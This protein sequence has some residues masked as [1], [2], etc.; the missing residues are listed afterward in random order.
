MNYLKK[1]ASIPGWAFAAA[2]VVYN[3]L[4]LHFWIMDQLHWG[5]LLAIA[6]FALGFGGILAL[7]TSLFDR[8][9]SKRAAVVLGV[10]VTVISL[11]EYFISDAYQVFMTPVTVISGAGGVATDYTELV[12]SLIA[13]NLWRIGLMLLPVVLYGIFGTSSGRN[14]KHSAAIALAAVLCFAAGVGAVRNMTND[15]AKLDSAYEFDS[16]V[17]SFGL[18][19]ALTLDVINGSSEDEALDFEVVETEPAVL[20]E[21]ETQPETTEATEPE[22]GY[23][24]IEGLD[25]EALSKDKK[26][27]AV[28]TVHSYVNSLTPSR[29][30]QYTGLFE[31]KNLIL[32][33]A[34]AFTAEVIDPE[35]TPTLYRMANKGIK[36]EEYY[37][38]AWGSSTTSGEFSNLV[39]L[40]PTNGGACMKETQQQKLFLTMGH[41]LQKLGYYSA[42]FHN[43]LATFYDRDKTHTKLGYDKYVAMYGG[44]E[45]V[46]AVWP[47]SDLELIQAT[48]DDYINNQPFSI[49]YMTVSG[50]SIYKYDENVQAR[51]HYDKVAHL[52]YPEPLKCYLAAQQE[53][54]AAMTELIARLEEAGIADDTVIVI[55]TDH[56]PY[57]LDRSGTWKNPEDYLNYLYGV[58]SYDHFVRD[59]NAL[60]IWSGCLE[61]MNLVVE[62]PTY[63]L[64]ILP[65][66]SNLF[67]VEYDSRLLI[68]RD[69]LSDTE[70]LAL[71]TNYS[72]KT[73]KATYNSKTGELIPNEG[74]ELPEGYKK[75]IDTLVKNKITFSRSVI[76]KNY[77]NY[78]VKAMEKEE[79]E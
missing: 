21:E 18:D 71:W 75:Q 56:F 13:R 73:D 68:G 37:Q 74:V 29:K 4:M 66:L 39:G 11:T 79:E 7:V 62:G 2:M 42:A 69:I 8:K 22:Y 5:R 24:V 51:K 35:L 40:V 16:A 64:D 50:H 47:E 34:E 14:W 44:L 23:N 33:T 1:F 77:Y 48:V 32:I 19:M 54:E 76:D 10:L 31:G 65:T 63:S 28:K 60:I 17:R 12:L 72:W 57:G 26:Q 52:D 70:P 78:V 15:A 27:A 46:K 30:N 45:G 61:D 3:E 38:P 59:H 9:G 49:Y 43:H 36:V 20:Q 58:E 25:F 55:S 67:G 41:Q 53:L 6:C